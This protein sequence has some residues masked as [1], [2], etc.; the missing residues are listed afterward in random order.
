M[1]PCH[2]QAKVSVHWP[3]LDK[4]LPNIWAREG[5]LPIC[6]ALVRPHMEYYVQFWAPLQKR[7]R[8]TESPVKSH[9]DDE[10]MEWLL[11]IGFDL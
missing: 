9:K 4:V 5:A 3:T 7:Y 10:I 8:H 1:C 6:S 2:N 11:R